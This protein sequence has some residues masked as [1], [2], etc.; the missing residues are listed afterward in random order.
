MGLI[1]LKMVKDFLTKKNVT[2]KI[3]THKPVYTS[4]EAANV[5]GVKLKTGVKTLIL[6]TKEKKFIMALVAAD[7]KIHFKKLKK[8]ALTKDLKLASPKEVFEKTG[9]EVGS[10]HPFGNLYHLTV[11]LDVSIMQ[12]D[13]VNF[14]AGLHIISIEMR[15]KDLIKI[16][17]PLIGNFSY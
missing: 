3:F 2:Y 16:V 13:L 5:R 10:V 6:K 17:N 9:C 7:K 4:K 15:M 1:E 11:Y 12:N 8:I 14:N